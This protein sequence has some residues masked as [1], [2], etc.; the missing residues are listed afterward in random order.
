MM[1]YA[2]KLCLIVTFAAVISAGSSKSDCE[3]DE[4]FFKDSDNN[5]NGEKSS[6][7]NDRD[8]DDSKYDNPKHGRS[9]RSN[10][11]SYCQKCNQ[12]S[13]V[14]LINKGNTVVLPFNGCQCTASQT[15][16]Y[17]PTYCL[18]HGGSK[19]CKSIAK[20]PNCASKMKIYTCCTTAI[21]SAPNPT[22]AADTTTT[23]TTT[24]TPPPETTVITLENPWG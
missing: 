2:V 16:T 6:S 14:E 21:P 20:K 1:R 17:D 9:K 10:R 13:R 18:T 4:D 5:S 11:V 22:P 12:V 23:T 7:I 15:L 3:V 8:S 24:T 19:I